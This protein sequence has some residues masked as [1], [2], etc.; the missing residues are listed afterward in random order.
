MALPRIDIRPARYSGNP[1]IE[2]S[3]A[4][5]HAAQTF[6]HY[7]FVNPADE[8]ELV[9]FLSG[10][11][12]PTQDG[13]ISIGLYTAPVSDPYTWT[14][15]GQVLEPSGV[16]STFD[17]DHVRLDCVVWDGSEFKLYY[18]GIDPSGVNQIGLATSAT[19]K[20]TFT[21]YESNPILTADGNGRDDG[22]MVS[23]S[24]VLKEGSDWTMVYS[25]RDGATI[26][27]G[28][29][30][31]TSSDGISWTKGG[32]GD[33]LTTAPLYGEWHQLI[34]INGLY[35]LIYEAGN[36]TTDFK[37]FA[38]TSGLVTGPYRNIPQNPIFEKSGEAGTFDEF[39]VATAALFEINGVWHLVYQGAEDHSQP[40]GTNHWSTGMAI[41]G[42]RPI[43]NVSNGGGR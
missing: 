28:Y 33:I 27:P 25:Y 6:D 19:A 31:A 20:A 37:I 7:I 40:Y 22:T 43:G 18:T 5:W 32:T 23:Q 42:E 16:G 4:A 1:I 12:L 30:Y 39:H 17:E 36:T 10:M 26:L 14:E 11:A 8:D 3:N 21:R 38:A 24:A 41:Y 13:V 29:R 9:M 35:Y 2:K 34:K 15:W